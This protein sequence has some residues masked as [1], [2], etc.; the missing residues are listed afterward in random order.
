L[1]KL[2]EETCQELGI[3]QGGGIVI[4]KRKDNKHVELLTDEQYFDLLEPIS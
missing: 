3:E 1:V 2:P 4:L